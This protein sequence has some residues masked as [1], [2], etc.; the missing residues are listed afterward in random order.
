M[1]GADVFGGSWVVQM[2]L[3]YPYLHFKTKLI[4]QRACMRA[5]LR[6]CL[7][8][9]AYRCMCGADDD[10]LLFS[11]GGGGADGGRQSERVSM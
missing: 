1:N 9:F 11:V 5:S 2:R 6:V 7:F 8:L 3:L 10:W 4:I